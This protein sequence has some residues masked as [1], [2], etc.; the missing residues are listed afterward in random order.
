MILGRVSEHENKWESI[1]RNKQ[2]LSHKLRTSSKR[3]YIAG[4]QFFYK[5]DADGE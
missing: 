4:D 1:G 5:R 2:A 3:K